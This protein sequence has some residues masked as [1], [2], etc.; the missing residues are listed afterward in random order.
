ML[1]PRVSVFHDFI[2]SPVFLSL[3]L[4]STQT[5]ANGGT[6]ARDPRASWRDEKSLINLIH[7]IFYG[8]PA[9]YSV[10]LY[11]NVERAE[12]YHLTLYIRTASATD[13]HT[14][15]G[16][17]ETRIEKPRQEKYIVYTYNYKIP[18]GELNHAIPF[19]SWHRWITS[20][21][22]H[23][24]AQRSRFRLSISYWKIKELITMFLMLYRFFNDDKLVTGIGTVTVYV[25]NNT[26]SRAGRYRSAI[27]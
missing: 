2:F 9:V 23:L 4:L 17:R 26:T 3:G 20:H 22:R 19:A 6:R 27:M 25:A 1:L 8:S 15:A 7:F 11:G 5:Q 10:C 13:K 12:G 18:Q 21:A 14:S 16:E 24:H